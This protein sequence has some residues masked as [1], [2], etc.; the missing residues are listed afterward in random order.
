MVS[1]CAFPT[2]HYERIYLRIFRHSLHVFLAQAG[3]DTVS[4]H[5]NRFLRF[6]GSI[7]VWRRVH[8]TLVISVLSRRQEALP[9]A[10]AGRHWQETAHIVRGGP[11]VTALLEPARG[12]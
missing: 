5:A 11:V 12:T 1:F 8:L 4:V 6:D 9:T 2:P 10:R 3:V 7:L